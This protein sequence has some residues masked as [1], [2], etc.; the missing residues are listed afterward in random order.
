MRQYGGARISVKALHIRVLNG[1]EV[2]VI[3]LFYDV[4]VRHD[5]ISPDQLFPPLE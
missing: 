4:E 3:E 5:P 1:S 2:V